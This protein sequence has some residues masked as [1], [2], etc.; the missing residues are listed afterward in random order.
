MLIHWYIIT[1]SVINTSSQRNPQQNVNV[2]KK[3]LDIGNQAQ[4]S[5]IFAQQG[6][7]TF[8]RAC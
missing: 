6:Q 5:I 1:K 7:G 8:G 2:I 4:G 3:Y